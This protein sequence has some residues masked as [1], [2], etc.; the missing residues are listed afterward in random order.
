MP[1]LCAT[2]RA[3]RTFSGEQQLR[4][5]ADPGIVPE[6]QSDADH[7]VALL[8]QQQG[9]HGAVHAAAHAH[10]HARSASSDCR[11]APT[12]QPG[13]PRAAVR[14]SWSAS[15][16]MPAVYSFAGTSPRSSADVGLSRRTAASRNEP[17]GHP[18]AHLARAGQRGRAAVGLVAGLLDHA[19]ADAQLDA[20]QAAALQAARLARRRRRPTSGP[21]KVHERRRSARRS[22]RRDPASCPS[23]SSPVDRT[24]PLQ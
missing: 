22:R 6:R 11:P 7:P 3:R 15:R 23:L 17:A 10:Q 2:L 5:S 13:E 18:G 21:A 1:R 8:L 19:R 20:H 24:G 16:A 4:S 12:S 14:A 9:G